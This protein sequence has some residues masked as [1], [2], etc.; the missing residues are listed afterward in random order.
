MR[1][2]CAFFCAQFWL[3]QNTV[4]AWFLRNFCAIFFA[5]ACAKKFAQKSRP[6]QLGPSRSAGFLRVCLRG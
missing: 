5:Q 1:V 3:A 6:A 4:T 2:F